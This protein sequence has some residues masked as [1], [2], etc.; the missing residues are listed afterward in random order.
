[1]QGGRTPIHYMAWKFIPFTASFR[2]AGRISMIIPILM[3]LLLLWIV[4]IGDRITIC[5]LKSRIKL[6]P[7]ALLSCA[8]LFGFAI[9][10]V[11]QLLL[12]PDMTKYSA[13]NI[14]GIPVYLEYMLLFS[15]IAAIIFFAVCSSLNRLTYVAG[16]LFCVFSCFTLM[17]YLS[18]GTWIEKKRKTPTFK[19]I[20]AEKRDRLDYRMQ[21]GYGLISK[22]VQRQIEASC[23]EPFLGKI[24]CKSRW[25]EDNDSA[26]RQ[27][28]IGRAVN[29]IVIETADP[30][31]PISVDTSIQKGSNEIRLV[32]AAFNKLVFKVYANCSG[33]FGFAYPFTG[34]WY[35]K[36]DGKPQHVYRA[37][38]AAHAVR[39]APGSHQIEFLYWSHAAALGILISLLTFASAGCVF[40]R[41]LVKKKF[42]ILF[43]VSIIIAT[44]VCAWLWYHSLYH[45]DNLNT[46][47]QWSSD[48]LPTK[49]NLAYGKPAYFLSQG[50]GGWSL[51]SYGGLAVDGNYN[52]LTGFK[53]ALKMNPYWLV[54]L[55]DI[56]RI[57][58]LILYE[59]LDG[60]KW[61][62]RPLKVLVSRD[63]KDWHL[64]AEIRKKMS[65][66]PIKK[67]FDKFESARYL[68]IEATGASRLSFDE[69]EIFAK[70]Y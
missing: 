9:V 22:V 45:G 32:Y 49:S 17:G 61:N 19:Q 38:G 70:D 67:V 34:H 16:I 59:S 26:Y 25:V 65:G 30:K 11:L 37:N 13:V 10:A 68:M 23:L 50:A 21:P 51:M 39:V 33:F 62:R 47:Y 56:H 36:V 64:S 5:F 4:K 3:L 46:H 69:I 54:D 57:G 58:S 63:G 12:T 53:S 44:I 28:A 31:P 60:G 42:A 8:T 41:I 35:A 43:S 48:S 20:Q 40:A 66:Q 7:A 24:Y 2:I 27:L 6:T 18:Q 15:S 55:H 14:R 52:P 1:M 29:E